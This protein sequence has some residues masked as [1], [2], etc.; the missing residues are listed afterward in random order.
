MSKI[1]LSVIILFV[2]FIAGCQENTKDNTEQIN[3]LEFEVFDH[4]WYASFCADDTTSCAKISAVY[5]MVSG[6]PAGIGKTIN[7]SILKFVKS[8]ISTF[9]QEESNADIPVAK[10][11]VEFF[12]EYEGFVSDFPDFE[13]PW[14]IEI[15]GK[16]L[17]NSGSIVSLELENYSF[18]GGAHPN[19]ETSL[20]SFDLIEKKTL[21]IEDIISD[22]EKLKAIAEDK[23]RYARN[24]SKE[25]SLE[26]AGFLFGDSFTLPAN[27]ALTENGLY[28]FYN[29]YEVG[30]YVLGYTSFTIPYKEIKPILKIKH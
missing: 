18:T 25:E 22:K 30:A 23:F 24:L 20:L 16:V 29:P 14:A 15:K 6:A 2:F 12:N 13:M 4:T 17:Y 21:S 1:S 19:Y 10:L 28:L 27:Y 26:N 5:P 9:E 7:D 8:S 3:D 11:V